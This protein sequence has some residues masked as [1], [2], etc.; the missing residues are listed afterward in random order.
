M[1]DTFVDSSKD[2]PLIEIIAMILD[3]FSWL[4]YRA[5]MGDYTKDFKNF[6][7]REKPEEK[8]PV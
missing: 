4:S 7:I 1:R 8:I 2:V 5:F 3:D 6:E